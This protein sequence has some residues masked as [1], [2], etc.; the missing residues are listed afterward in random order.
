MTG[1]VVSVKG[2]K[3]FRFTG[4]AGS[5]DNGD[6]SKMDSGI[7]R[8]DDKKGIRYEVRHLSPLRLSVKWM[9][10]LRTALR[11]VPSPASAGMTAK[12]QSG[13]EAETLG[14]NT[15]L[16]LVFSA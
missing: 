1:V 9:C 6:S 8:N 7:R 11:R 10:R 12:R 4:K 13:M 2:Q 3:T 14:S 15:L 5:D 16:S